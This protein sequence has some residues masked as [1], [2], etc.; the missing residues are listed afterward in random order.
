MKRPWPGEKASQQGLENLVSSV[1]SL[2]VVHR[3]KPSS[4]LRKKSV[5]IKNIIIGL[6]T[7]LSNISDINC[8]K[9]SKENNQDIAIDVPIRNVTTALVLALSSKI[10][11]KSQLLKIK[12]EDLPV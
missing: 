1:V 9:L 11:L 4:R 5:I 12:N 2:E 7:L 6:L 3:E 8:G 10:L